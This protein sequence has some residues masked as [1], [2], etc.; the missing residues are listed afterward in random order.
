MIYFGW[1]GGVSL[2]TTTL[3]FLLWTGH[4]AIYV[5]ASVANWFPFFVVFIVSKFIDSKATRNFLRMLMYASSIGSW[6]FVWPAYFKLL[7]GTAWFSPAESTSISTDTD[8]DGVT[9]TTTT[10]VTA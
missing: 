3:C 1:S 10:T 7:Y 6:S 8:E 9:T 4:D 2:V 5:L